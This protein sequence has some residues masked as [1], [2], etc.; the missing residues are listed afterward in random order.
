MHRNSNNNHATKNNHQPTITARNHLIGNRSSTPLPLGTPAAKE[1]PPTTSSS[2][3]DE[4]QSLNTSTISVKFPLIVETNQIDASLI[5]ALEQHYEPDKEKE[6]ECRYLNSVSPCEIYLMLK[7]R[8]QILN[9]LNIALA[10]WAKQEEANSNVENVNVGKC[11]TKIEIT[12][13]YYSH[14]WF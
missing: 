10:K 2:T 9:R 13:I 14:R 11:D 7:N 1:T 5:A 3:T 8:E 6:L 12:N 4:A